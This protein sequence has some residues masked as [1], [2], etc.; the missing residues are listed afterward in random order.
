MTD[1]TLPPPR[2][3]RPA[4]PA[5]PTLPPQPGWR[6]AST[7]P[8][9]AAARKSPGRRF[10]YIVLGAIA[11]GI[12]GLI[13]LGLVLH[14]GK[15]SA[16][17]VAFNYPIKWVHGQTKFAAQS[18][19]AVWSESFGPSSIPRVGVT[20]SQYSLQADVSTVSPDAVKAEVTA[21]VD[22]LAQQLNGTVTRGISSVQ[23]AGMQ[24]YE[25][26][27]NATIQGQAVSVD[28]T[29]L[30]RGKT[31]YNIGCQATSLDLGD[32]AEGCSQIK[33]SFTVK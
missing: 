23:M 32:V 7:V 20:V 15:Y 17:G 18:G 30:F 28:L 27:L 25:V 5:H 21:L 10:L 2:P 24:G 11:L 8:P 4:V 33:S 12:A 26:T 29:M 3:E 13:V 14:P 16:H 1:S 31:Q 22:N 9:V 19:S 6:P